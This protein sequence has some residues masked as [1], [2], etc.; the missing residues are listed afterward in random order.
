M[1]YGPD[2]T[3]A[4]DIARRAGVALR[5][6]YRYFRNKQDAVGPLLSAGGDHWRDLLAATEP[7]TALP[8]ALEKAIKEALS[9]PDEHAAEG[10]NLTRALLRAAVDD[11]ALRAVWYRVNQDSE[12]K[13]IPV[14]ARLA[15]AEADPWR[16]ASPPRRPRTRSGS[17]WRPGRRRTP[18]C[19]GRA[20]R[21]NWRC[22]VC[23]NSWA[24]CVRCSPAV[25]R[26]R[27]GLIRAGTSGS[28][29]H[30][31][32]RRARL[33]IRGDAPSVRHPR[34]RRRAGTPPAGSP[35]PRTPRTRRAS[36]PGCC[37]PARAV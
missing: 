21:P 29:G 15:G 28:G 7:G 36:S 9:S 2:G 32:L 16:P 19:G 8:E 34:T 26:G 5:T 14:V 10:L 25:R 18:T 12:E 27:E 31:R 33:R 6:F 3:T 35:P 13:L 4:E 11:P 30:F 20:P 23:V 17:P 37:A 1:E 24:E 22:G